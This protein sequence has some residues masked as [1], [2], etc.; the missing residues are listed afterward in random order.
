MNAADREMTLFDHLRELRM[1]LL[2]SVIA[3]VVGACLA[4]G[5][6]NQIFELLCRPFFDSFKD[7]A[8]IGTGPADAFI[9]KI[10]VALVAGAIIASPVIFFQIWIF[11]SPGLR[12]E[13]K[14]LLIPFLVSTTSLF[15]LGMWFSYTAV[16]PFAFQ[17]FFEQYG[18]INISPQIRITEHISFM[19]K[20]VLS[21][22]IVFEM[23][24]LAYFLGRLGIVTADLLIKGFR[25]A[26]VVIFIVSAIMTPPDVFTQFLMAGP[27]LV[28]YG[29]SILI[30]RWAERPKTQTTDLKTQP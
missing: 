27:L 29:L 6:S 3:T 19:A 16:L 2:I 25:I 20:A 12:P 21:F 30:V 13:E 15:F 14:K 1:R 9:L 24:V 22:G 8:L 4:Y 5:F 17:F 23:P 10:K 28:L 18:S 11:I 26:V 7:G